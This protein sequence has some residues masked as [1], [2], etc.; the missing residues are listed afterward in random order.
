[1]PNRCQRLYKRYLSWLLPRHAVLTLPLCLVPTLLYSLAQSVQ[2]LPPHDLLSAWDA[3]IPL[4]PEWLFVYFG[5]YVTWVVNFVLMMRRPREEWFRCLSAFLW[6]GII[7]FLIYVFYPTTMPRPEI[8]DDVPLAS[9]MRWMYAN[10]QPLN[11]LPSLHCS[12][13]W[14]CAI[15]LY[16]DSRTPRWYRVASYVIAVAVFCST[17]FVRQHCLVDIAAG[18]ALAQVA[19]T[20]LS[21]L[22]LTGWLMR[23]CTRLEKKV[24]GA[25]E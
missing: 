24:F 19:Y 4:K 20:G 15:G 18:V 25:A 3:A 1:M 2:W 12:A 22:P 23:G 5:C 7:G 13:S 21:R 9:M 14:L 8:A 17:V 16:G 11:L 6:I 10:D